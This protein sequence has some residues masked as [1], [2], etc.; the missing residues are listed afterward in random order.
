[1]N[2]PELAHTV[3]LFEGLSVE[4]T[5]KLLYRLNGVLKTYQ[6]GEIVVHAGWDIDRLVL[7]ISG[8]LQVYVN[9]SDIKEPQVLVRDIGEGETVGLWA[10]HVPAMTRWA[11]TIV[12]A[13]QSNLISLD[14]ASMR[15]LLE[16]A[17]GTPSVTRL[18]VNMAR[19]LAEQLLSTWRKLM[20]M[21]ETTIESRVMV[22]LNELDNESGHTGTVI[23]PFNRNH[24]AQYFG[25]ARP[26]ISR[27][28]CH[29]R[30]QGL[31][32]WRK[33]VFVLTRQQ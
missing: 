12:A 15:L 21:N 17:K 33:N 6:S 10:L 4:E 1:M 5:D 19:Q 14:M 25:V 27:A 16:D 32:T 20:V 30:D 26:S 11:G 8:H 18:A 7:V 28:L 23:V 13:E 9:S 3:K 22:Y 2:L 24:M 31:I 29:L